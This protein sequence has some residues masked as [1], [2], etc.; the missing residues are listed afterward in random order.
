MLVLMHR[1]PVHLVR[2]RTWYLSGP[3]RWRR[4]ALL[5]YVGGILRL[6]ETC[7]HISD[8]GRSVTSWNTKGLLSTASAPGS[9]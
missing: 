6:T 8:A 9:R 5:P 4:D 7:A 2:T 1:T 3:F